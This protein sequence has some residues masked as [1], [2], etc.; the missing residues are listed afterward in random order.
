MCFAVTAKMD[1]T[2]KAPD[3]FVLVLQFVSKVPLLPLIKLMCPD[4]C[5]ILA[6]GALQHMTPMVLGPIKSDLKEI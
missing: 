6:C 3:N 2:G 1:I 5:T 4:I